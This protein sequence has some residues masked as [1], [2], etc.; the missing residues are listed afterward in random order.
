MFI[1]ERIARYLVEHGAADSRTIADALQI[2]CAS[3]SDSIRKDN[4]RARWGIFVADAPPGVKYPGRK[5]NMWDINHRQFARYLELRGNMVWVTRKAFTGA[6]SKPSRPRRPRR[7][8][9]TKS[10]QRRL[11]VVHPTYEGPLRTQWQPASP[12]YKEKQ[13]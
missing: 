13:R 8:D 11:T 12:Y 3:V 1:V 6:P 5:P 2:P 4:V 9:L 10:E 7:S